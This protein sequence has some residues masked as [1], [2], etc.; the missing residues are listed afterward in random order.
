[1]D[2][3]TALWI[4]VAAVVVGFLTKLASDVVWHRS[5]RRAKGDLWRARAFLKVVETTPNVEVAPGYLREAEELQDD[6]LVRLARLQALRPRKS[7]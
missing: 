3:E 6:A 4:F 1:M 5:V 7:I 2:L